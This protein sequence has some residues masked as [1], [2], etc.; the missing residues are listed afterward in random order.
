MNKCLAEERNLPS[1]KERLKTAFAQNMQ[2]VVM[3]LS[4]DNWRTNI[5]NTGG[6]YFIETNTPIATLQGLG[7]PKGENHRN[8]PSVIAYSQQLIQNG[9][10]I[11][12]QGKG[13]YAVYNGEAKSLK[14]RAREHVFG[15][16]KTY[17]LGLS[18]YQA[19]KKYTWK[20]WFL[21][22]KKINLPDDKG[23]KVF[24][25]QIWRSENGWPILCKR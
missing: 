4:V 1:L 5:P 2:S 7:S 15:S 19:L 12:R 16:S 17:C 24:G 25:E 21:S 23:I 6:W 10:A 22:T 20:F 13:M 3:D 8:I 11:Q 9:L 14:A 18:N